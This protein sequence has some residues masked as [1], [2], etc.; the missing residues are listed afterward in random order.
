VSLQIDGISKLDI[1]TYPAMRYSDNFLNSALTR[2]V[3]AN[4]D[5]GY[6][7]Q[8]FFNPAAMVWKVNV[9]EVNDT[10]TGFDF[11]RSV[12]VSASNIPVL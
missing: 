2:F 3:A 6:Y 8:A 9:Y 11:V 7:Y 4:K 1:R 12:N 5:T 10:R